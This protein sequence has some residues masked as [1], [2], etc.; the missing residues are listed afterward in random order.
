[1]AEDAF[2]VSIPRR[3]N[4]DAEIVVTFR[5]RSL[6]GSRRHILR[7]D[8]YPVHAPSHPQRHHGFWDIP[9]YRIR[10]GRTTLTFK[11]GN[12]WVKGR[13]FTASFP[14]T[15]RGTLPL[16]GPCMVTVSMLDLASNLPKVIVTK[17]SHHVLSDAD[18][19]PFINIS[20]YVTRI[21][22]L[23]CDGCWRES[24]QDWRPHCAPLAPT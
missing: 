4:D 16:A 13:L 3:I 1:M 14:P 21:C 20:L 11:D 12:V 7:F 6:L 18:D 2:E 10:N 8:V 19:F 9:M 15:W 22:N 17:S 5:D 23:Q 24:F